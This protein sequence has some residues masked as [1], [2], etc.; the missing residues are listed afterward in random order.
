MTRSPV[1]K[2]VC[3]AC[4]N[5]EMRCGPGCELYEPPEGAEPPQT[6]SLTL[7]TLAD[8]A[9]AYAIVMGQES[10]RELAIPTEACLGFLLTYLPGLIQLATEHLSAAEAEID[11]RPLASIHR[12][13]QSAY[14][15]PVPR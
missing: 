10:P 12:V 9:A 14:Q 5:G 13:S 3:T 2:R 7:D 4:K 11:G 8:L 1:Y 6:L 15:R